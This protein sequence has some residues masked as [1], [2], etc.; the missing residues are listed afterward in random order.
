MYVSKQQ[1]CLITQHFATTTRLHTFQLGLGLK[2]GQRIYYY[3]LCL[4]HLTFISVDPANPVIIFHI[5]I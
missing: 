4:L 2:A 5:N 1:L 3:R